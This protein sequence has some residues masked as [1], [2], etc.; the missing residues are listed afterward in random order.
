MTDNY[1]VRLKPWVQQLASPDGSDIQVIGP[2]DKL[3]PV[4]TVVLIMDV[5][6]IESGFYEVVS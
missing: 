6:G 3:P 2:G 4:G 1:K 5:P